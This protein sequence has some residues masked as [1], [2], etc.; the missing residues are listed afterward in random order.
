MIV[1]ADTSVIV[2]LTCVGHAELLRHLYH[3]VWIPRKVAEEFEWQTSVN[4][5]FREL[6]LPPWLHVHDPSAISEDLQS[7]KSLDDGE[8]AALALALEIHADAI[9]IDEE[10][11]RRIAIEMGLH[12]VGILGILIRAKSQGL[13]PALKPVIDSLKGK[14]NFWISHSLREEILRHAGEKP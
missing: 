12:R 4:L 14:A 2:N 1:V 5:R 9:L 11:G 13:V 10:N 7:N 3:E 8:R 6:R